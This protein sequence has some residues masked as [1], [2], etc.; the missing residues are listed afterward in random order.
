MVKEKGGRGMDIGAIIPANSPVTP[1]E[2]A[3]LSP[4]FEMK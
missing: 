3:I 1:C 2:E 4:W